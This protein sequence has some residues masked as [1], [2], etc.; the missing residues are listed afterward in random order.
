VRAAISV[1]LPLYRTRA[2]VPE[3]IGRLAAAL[4]PMASSSGTQL[5]FVDDACPEASYEAVV[6]H[7]PVEATTVLLRRHAINRGQHAAVVT[8]LAA[9]T[10]RLVAVMDADLQDA[11]ED[12]PVLVDRLRTGGADLVAAGRRAGYE[13][14]GREW[15]GRC[16]RRMVHR[17]SG[18]TVPPDAGLFLV[19][20]RELAE[21]IVG[22]G[23]RAV[24]PV[25]A[26]ARLGARI[27]SVPV[28]RRPRPGGSSAYGPAGRLR[29]AARALAVLT[30][31]Y[32]A[33]RRVAGLRR[34]SP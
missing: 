14:P 16:Y 25:P 27:E 30:P 3:L 10:G 28:Q 18:G 15:T 21:R 32:P 34:P 9:A 19:M 31:I 33:L 12:L 26:A 29:V 7:P 11:P 17:L 2:H 6:A 22:L 20:H 1:V 24:H 8:G 5:V 23:D 4:A 13:R